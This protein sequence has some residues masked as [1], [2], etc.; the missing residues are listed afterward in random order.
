MSSFVDLALPTQESAK[1]A[2][3]LACPVYVVAVNL[4]SSE[5][6]LELTKSALLAAMEGIML[7]TPLH[8]HL[9]HLDQQL[10]GR[11]PRQQV[12]DWMVF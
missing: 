10:H 12:K 9:K 8:L 7:T 1:E 2:A 3:M 11:E 5:E 6:F 4:S